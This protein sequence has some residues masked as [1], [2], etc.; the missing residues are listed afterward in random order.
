MSLLSARSAA[1]TMSSDG[2]PVGS[3]IAAASSFVGI[4]WSPAAEGGLP[5]PILQEAAHAG[6]RILGGEHADEAHPLVFQS[7]CQVGL[8][9]DVDGL[10]CGGKRE[11][12]ASREPGRQLAGR[13]IHLIV[14]H[15]LVG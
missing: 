4:R 13:V 2:L 5:R 11:S 12:R 10:L 8:E 1:V 9:A 6:P 15:D 7:R 3:I 14:R